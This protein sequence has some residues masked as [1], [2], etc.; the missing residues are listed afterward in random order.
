[1]NSET[2]LKSDLLD[3]LFDK[4]NKTYGAY[5]LRKFYPNRIKT[6]LLIMFGMVIVFSAFTFLPDKKITAPM[7]DVKDGIVLAQQPLD[8]QPDIIKPKPKTSTSSAAPQAN[9]TDNMEIVPDKDSTK[10]FQNISKM[11]IGDTNYL[12]MDGSGTEDAAPKGGGTGET[13]MPK[14][15][16]PA[17]VSNEPTNNPDVQASFPG[18]EKEL[19]RFLQ[20]NLRSP[21]D[22]EE[23]E[24]VEVRIKYVVGF[25]GNLQSFS[26]AKDGGEMFNSEVIRVLKKMPKWNAGKKAG[27]NVP[28]YYTI[29]VKFTSIE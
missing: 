21:R 15:A 11:T 27:Q 26:V 23:G 16:E 2:I 10:I 13:V 8:K 18:G 25:D 28:V 7:Y 1:M 29:P 5:I 14:P 9:F 22:M 20:K 12:L 17:A 24:T 6:S 19:I 3:I 4:R